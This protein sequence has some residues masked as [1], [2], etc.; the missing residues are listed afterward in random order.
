MQRPTPP[1][2]RSS[3]YIV[4]KSCPTCPHAHTCSGTTNT[5]VKILYRVR[6]FCQLSTRKNT[7]SL[8]IDLQALPDRWL[9]SPNSAQI[10]RLRS[11]RGPPRRPQIL[12]ILT[13]VAQTQRQR[14]ITERQREIPELLWTATEVTGAEPATAIATGG[15]ANPHDGQ[16]SRSAAINTSH[17]FARRTARTSANICHR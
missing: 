1:P 4:I 5:A 14:Y 3:L 17:R 2:P 7:T 10:D 13:D 9:V 6:R 15:A 16:R 8:I 11:L 12:E